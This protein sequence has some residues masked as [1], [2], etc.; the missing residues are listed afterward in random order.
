MKR[1]IVLSQTLLWV[2]L[3]CLLF[4]GSFE[5]S[6]T[7]KESSE[8]KVT[9]RKTT[10]KGNKVR[11]DEPDGDYFVWDM[12]KKEGFRTNASEKTYTVGTWKGL[13]PDLAN[14]AFANTTVTKTGKSDKIAGYACDVY[15]FKDEDGSGEVCLTKGLSNP[16]F[17][18]MITGGALG[19]S[20]PPWLRDLAKEGGFPLRAVNRDETGQVESTEEAMKIEPGKLDDSLFAPPAGYGKL[21][22]EDKM[23][24]LKRMIEERHGKRDGK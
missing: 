10:F 15:H 11:I 13:P 23:Q 9:Q 19:Q 16:A 5:G 1:S 4:A 24:E 20:V 2:G 3:P 14:G 17:Y 18:Q 8:G 21:T 22:Q 6:V 7:M 12:T